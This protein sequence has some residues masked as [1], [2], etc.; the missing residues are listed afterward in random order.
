MTTESLAHLSL[1]SSCGATARSTSLDPGSPRM[2]TYGTRSPYCGSS[3]GSSSIRRAA[4]VTPGGGGTLSLYR[5]KISIRSPRSIET[6]LT[7]LYV[8]ILTS[9]AKMKSLMDA[10]LSSMRPHVRQQY[11]FTSLKSCV[12]N[13]ILDNHLDQFRGGGVQR[14]PTLSRSP[15]SSAGLGCH[16]GEPFRCLSHRTQVL[17]HRGSRT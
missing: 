16:R 4:T 15:S 14:L 13:K 11:S 7:D 17:C 1:N 8:P 2:I 9:L 12:R 6:T 10:L 3:F 5:A